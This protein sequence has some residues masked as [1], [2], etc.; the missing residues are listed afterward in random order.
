MQIYSA[1]SI[2][3]AVFVISNGQCLM[4]LRIFAF[5]G[6]QAQVYCLWTARILAVIHVSFC[7]FLMGG[8]IRL[9]LGI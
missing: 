5:T 1:G 7:Y 6:Q 2:K 4:M 9:F 8:G 3:C